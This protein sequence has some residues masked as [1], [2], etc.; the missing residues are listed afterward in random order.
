MKTLHLNPIITDLKYVGLSDGDPRISELCRRLIAIM[1][2]SN[3]FSNEL[4]AS[5]NAASKS[6]SFRDLE[7]AITFLYDYSDSANIWLGTAEDTPADLFTQ[8]N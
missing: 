5:F 8:P 6:L 3:L 1:Q 2:L 4:I 7:Q